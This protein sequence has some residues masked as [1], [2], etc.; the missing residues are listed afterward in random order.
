LDELIQK[1]KD[2]NLVNQAEKIKETIEKLEKAESKEKIRK[3]LNE[4]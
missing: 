4:S 2:D 1:A 3:I